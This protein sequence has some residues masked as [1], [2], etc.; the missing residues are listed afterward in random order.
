[1]A[2]NMI[3]H[4]EKFGNF[5]SGTY[6]R[7]TMIHS[8]RQLFFSIF[9][10]LLQ[11]F[12]GYH[13]LNAQ[14]SMSE[15]KWNFLTDVYLMFPYM[16]GETGIGES[17]ILPVD[18]NPGDIFSKLKM[19]AMLYF[20]AKTDKWAV[21]SDLVYMNLNQEVTPGTILNSGD[22]TAKQLIWEAAGL[23]RIT[24]FLEAGLGGR[25]NYL[26]TGMDV[27]RN[28]LPAGT[29]EVTGHQSKTWYDPV[30]IARFTTDIKNKW[31]FQFRGDIGGFGVGSDLTWQLHA[32]VGYRFTK[33]FQMSLGYRILSTDYKTG[34]E[35][36]EFLFDVN[37]FGPE[38]RF[39]FNF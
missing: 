20:E 7:H 28:V 29:E 9:W 10:S 5:V 22:V 23:Y 37:E 24:S 3:K 15:K 2:N 11:L 26:E 13:P 36:K 1:M 19:G 33:V 12:I 39:G 32:S 21:T 14:S 27:R 16:D 6:K 34:E 35:P 17:L 38:I 4:I 30:L 25:L 18:A 31:L 8:I